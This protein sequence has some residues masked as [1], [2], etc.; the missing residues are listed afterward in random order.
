MLNSSPFSR[1]LLNHLREALSTPLQGD[2]I[3]AVDPALIAAVAPACDWLSRKYYRLSVEGLDSV[4]SGKAL[5]VGNHNSGVSF[6]EAMGVGAR[7]YLERGTDDI[8]HTLAHDA[9]INL[10]RLNR[11]LIRTGALRAS[12]DSA[13]KAF[14]RGRKVLVFPGG[15]LEA[16]RPY[17]ERDRVDFGNRT[18]FIKLALR[19]GVPIVPAVFAG[20]HET[21]IILNDGQSIARHLKLDKIPI[22]RSST[23]PLM[24]AFPWG[25]VWGPVPHIPFPAKCT[26][27]FLEPIS[28]DAY[29][30]DDANNPEA[31]REIYAQ[32]VNTMQTN[33]SELYETRRFPILG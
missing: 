1:E 33:L 7:W 5:I 28:L 3:D 27:R 26:T 20:G 19:S 12:H 9:V 14:D 11:F 25:L 13:Q 30:P 17:K 6:Y 22:L 29:S 21:F 24:L 10:P 32:V 23:W 4:P 2:P 18:G 15:N 16:F 8:L 31:L